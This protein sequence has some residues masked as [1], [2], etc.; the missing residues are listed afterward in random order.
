MLRPTGIP[1]TALGLPMARSLHRVPQPVQQV[2]GARRID[3]TVLGRIQA[4]LDIE[5]VRLS[6]QESAE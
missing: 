1:A 5:E 6:R 3:D 4:A 2:A